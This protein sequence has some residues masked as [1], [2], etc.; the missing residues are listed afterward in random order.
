MQNKSKYLD[1]FISE[2]DCSDCT[3]LTSPIADSVFPENML[4]HA[5]MK[6]DWMAA[7]SAVP[8]APLPAGQLVPPSIPVGLSPGT[9]FWQVFLKIWRQPD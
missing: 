2:T 4:G 7:G 8:E 6:L 1:G 9:P 5:Y 3:F